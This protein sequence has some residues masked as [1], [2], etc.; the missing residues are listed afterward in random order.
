MCAFAVAVI[1]L[2]A[3][4]GTKMDES[5]VAIDLTVDAA[6]GRVLAGHGEATKW[7]SIYVAARRRAIAAALDRALAD[8]SRTL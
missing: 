8:A 3:L 7:G 1:G 2:A 6:D 5:T 4:T